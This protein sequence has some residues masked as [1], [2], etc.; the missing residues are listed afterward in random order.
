MVSGTLRATSLRSSRPFSPACNA[1]VLSVNSKQSR[2]SKSIA[3]KSI[4][5][6]SIFEKSRMSLMRKRKASVEIITASRYSRCSGV[7]SVS[8]ASS[9]IPIIPFRG[10]RISWLILARNSLLARLAASAI[11][12]AACATCLSI[13][14]TFVALNNFSLV[15]ARTAVARI[16][17]A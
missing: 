2:R 17:A 9:V 5:P 14:A 16:R 6:A 11:W 4:F 12:H 7:S 3:S 8:R 13:S 10:V 1:S 15:S